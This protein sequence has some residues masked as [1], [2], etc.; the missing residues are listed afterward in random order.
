[1]RASCRLTMRGSSS[2][3]KNRSKNSSRLRVKRNSSTPC[4]S[5]LACPRP[6]P[7]PPP[8][9]G[10]SIWSPWL[11]RS[12]P[13]CTDSRT[14]PRP[15]WNWGSPM[16]CPGTPIFSPLSRSRMLR[17]AIASDTARR[18][19][20]LKRRRKRLRLT[21]I[22]FR[23]SSLRSTIRTVM[24]PLRQGWTFRPL[25]RSAAHPGFTKTCAHACTSRTA[26]GP[27]FR[28]S[29]CR[30]CGRQSSGASS[31]LGTGLGV[32]RDHRQQVFGVGEHL[33]RDHRAQLLV[34]GPRGVVTVVLGAGPQHKVDHL[35]AEVLGVADAGRLLDLFEF[36]VQ[37]PAIQDLAGVGVA[38]LLVLDPE[39]SVGH[40]A[41]EDVLAVLGVALQVGGLDLLAD[42]L[43]I[44]RAEKLL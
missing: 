12:L 43:G 31:G 27:A 34:A 2:S 4:P 18:T 42:E 23:L 29:P 14:P 41:V 5:G 17:L 38:E 28:C 26:G 11:K 3:S 24:R 9:G 21:E 32:E 39:I 15:W 44:A 37:G 20:V 25:G 33:L 7:C 1:M 13:G 36:V 40:I 19:W 30:S 35:V 8:P 10:R 6:L 16:S 22:L